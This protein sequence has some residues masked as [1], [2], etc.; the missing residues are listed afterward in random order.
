[1]GIADQVRGRAGEF[2]DDPALLGDPLPVVD[3]AGRQAA[4]FVPVVSGG[5]LLGF[6]ELLPSLQH[7]RSSWFGNP[8]GSASGC[9]S[10]R[11]WLDVEAVAD[12]ARAH[13]RPGEAA[14]TPV[15]SFDGAPD[16]L[17]WAV[18]VTG[19]S[20]ART[21]WVAGDASWSH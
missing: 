3:A 18:P 14:G 7:R 10:A 4:W 15:L 19:P 5:A 1:M 12:R 9:P 6:V 20:G 13:L 8:P 21:I 11:S 16:R 2:V 17:A